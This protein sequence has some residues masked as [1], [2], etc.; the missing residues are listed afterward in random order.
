MPTTTIEKLQKDALAMSVA[1]AVA[2]ANEAAI[3]QG[4]DPEK[5]LITIAEENSPSG[6][7]WRISYVPRDYVNRRGGDLIVLVDSSSQ[8]VQRILRGQ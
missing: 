1:S 6:T 3:A 7:V 4:R 2:V 8:T 5:S